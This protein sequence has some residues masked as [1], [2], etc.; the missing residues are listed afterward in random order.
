MWVSHETIYRAVY[1][2]A[3]RNLPKAT[4]QRLRSGRTMRRPRLV[5]RSHGRGHLCDMVSIS[6]YGIF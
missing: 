6:C 5:K 2:P 1:L 3:S 4:Y